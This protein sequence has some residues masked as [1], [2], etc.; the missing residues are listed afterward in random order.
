VKSQDTVAVLGDLAAVAPV[1]IAVLCAQNGVANEREALRLFPDV[2]A[3]CVILPAG[4]LAPGVVLQYAGPCPGILDLGRYPTGADDRATQM[5]A[6]LVAAGFGSAV[7]PH[8]MRKKYRK[9]ILN[10]GNAIDALC[11]SAAR[12]S[13][14]GRRA[15]AEADACLAA[16]GIEVQS[17]DEEKRWRS[18]IGVRQLPGVTERG[19]S[20][21]QS[22]ARGTGSIE[23]DWL[24][25]EIVLLGRLH[26]I[27]T[28]VNEVLQ[29]ESNAA[30]RARRPPR[31]MPVEELEAQLAP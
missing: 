16:A 4:H 2:Y 10:L 23:A 21:W 14:L 25:G 13:D 3:Q 19:S 26:G 7:D 22:L 9:L 20:S 6:D 8:V 17:T 28:P 15:Q 24:N 31:S 5:A 27:P 1:G 30:A 18:T 11:G 29:R 12:Q